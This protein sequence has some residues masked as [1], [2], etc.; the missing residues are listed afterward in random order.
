MSVEAGIEMQVVEGHL[1]V[2]MV[3]DGGKV[4]SFA[5]L[6]KPRAAGFPAMASMVAEELFGLDDEEDPGSTLN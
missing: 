6:D 3:A 5:K 1:V 2:R 4:I